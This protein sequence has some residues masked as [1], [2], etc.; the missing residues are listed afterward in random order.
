MANGH[1]GPRPNSGGKRAGAGRPPGTLNRKTLAANEIA[2]T[3]PTSGTPLDFMLALMH[4]PSFDLRLRLDAAKTAAQYV[5]LKK[6]DGGIKDE[7]K[8]A[9]TK[10]STGKFSAIPPPFK[11]V[12]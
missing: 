4:D 6:A 9:A 1:G 7:K 5:H 3:L 2:K 10:A 12:T 8:A 11:L